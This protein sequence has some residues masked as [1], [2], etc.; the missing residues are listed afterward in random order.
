MIISCFG[1]RHQASRGGKIDGGCS[2]WLDGPV[3]ATHQN[4]GLVVCDHPG[5][6]DGAVAVIDGIAVVYMMLLT[7]T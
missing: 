6:V 1:E 4:Q 3:T 5:L 7:V 2:S